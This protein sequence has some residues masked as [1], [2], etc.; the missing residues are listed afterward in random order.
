MTKSLELLPVPLHSSSQNK[1]AKLCKEYLGISGKFWLLCCCWAAVCLGHQ[2]V[3]SSPGEHLLR[4]SLRFKLGSRVQANAAAV[5]CVTGG[6]FG[7]T[8]AW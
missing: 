1:H 8:V 5:P 4:E 2:P 7:L 6:V 3:S